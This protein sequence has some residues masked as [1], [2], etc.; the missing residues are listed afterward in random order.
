MGNILVVEDEDSIR[1]FIVINLKREGFGV[2][3]AATGEEALARLRVNPVDLI[4]LD[5]ML[6]GIDGY[7]VCKRVQEE[8]PGTAI[9]MLTAKGQDTDKVIGLELG[10]DDYV[11]KPFNPVELT[12]RVKAV[13]R[14]LNRKQRDQK[15]QIKDVTIDTE[16]RR[17]TANGKPLD[18][19]NKE[20]ELFLLL[21]ETGGGVVTRE[22]IL[23]KLWG[24]NFYGDTKTIDVHIRRLREK[25]GDDPSCPR[26]IATVWGVGYRFVMEEDD[27]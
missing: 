2:I 26:Y 3:E 5:I 23:N 4:I 13:L 1:E 21:I 18:L 7:E 8:R 22:E 15:I 14:R 17:V 20:Y 12:A 10:A 11:V 9:I 24:T 27:V 25:L 6:P 16:K 19:T